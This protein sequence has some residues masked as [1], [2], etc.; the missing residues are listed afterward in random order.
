MG[1]YTGHLVTL[2]NMNVRDFEFNNFWKVLVYH[3]VVVIGKLTNHVDDH[4]T[5]QI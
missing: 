1:P 3:E 5:P 2:M 4:L